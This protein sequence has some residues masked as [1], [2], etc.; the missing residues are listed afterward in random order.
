MKRSDGL[1]GLLAGVAIGALGLLLRN[2]GVG[3]PLEGLYAQMTYWLG[4][5]AVFNLIHNLFGYGDLGKN[6]AF[7]AAAGGWLLLHPFLLAALRR[8]FW[9][10]LGLSAAVYWLLG[11]WVLLN[12]AAG[13]WAALVYGGLIA[14]FAW[15]AGRG[16]REAEKAHA[17]SADPG[18]RESIKTLGLM[19]VALSTGAAL[20]S[21]AKA[22]ASV[23]WGRIADLSKEQ[24]GQ[25]DLYVVSKNIAILDPR[26]KGKPWRLEL[27]GLVDKPQG[28]D[29]G[30][31]Q[32]LPAVELLNTMT[33]ISNPVGGD[34]IG[35]VRWK[36]VALREVLDR[37]GVKPAAKFIVWE[38]AD[39]FVE[40]I[41]LAEVP[42]EAMLAYAVQNPETGQFEELEERH[43]YP[44]RILLP[45]RYGMKQP[46]W[47]TK[48]TLSAN[49]VTGYWAN[50][51]WSRTAVIRTMSRIDT[52]KNRARVAANLDT[53]IAGVA[54]AG[55][56]ALERV[57]VSTDGGKTWQKAQLNPPKGNF[58]WAQWALPWKPAAGSYEI[59][60][61]AV[62]VGERVQSA[63]TAEPLP[64]GSSGYHKVSVRVG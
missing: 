54:F 57:E 15:L 19:A 49:E 29:L 60:V 51:G 59:Q 14:V 35:S 5:P 50:R 22:Q 48:I 47:L 56:R 45:G 34:L 38:A 46:K 40:S 25:K 55:G 30:A 39:R 10:G 31:I 44:L 43:G 26:L 21:Q 33:C 62:E 1:W 28:F 8:G 6:L 23:V 12:P 13:V 58:A 7:V 24:F 18:R 4:V 63:A 3:W 16:K 42:P 17:P 41:P 36:G 52:P 64:D 9:A 27:G 53:F 61:R 2:Y 20:W 11:G 32:A 37:V